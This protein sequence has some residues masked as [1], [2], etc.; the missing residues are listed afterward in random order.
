MLHL[1]KFHSKTKSYAKLLKLHHKMSDRENTSDLEESASS[2]E[3]SETAKSNG[4]IKFVRELDVTGSSIKEIPADF[5]KLQCL[6]MN[7]CKMEKLPESVSKLPALEELSVRRN[8]LQTLN[9]CTLPLKSLN[10][11]YNRITNEGIPS[12]V[13]SDKSLECVSLRG[14]SLTEMPEDLKLAENLLLLDLSYN[15]IKDLSF[16]NKGESIIAIYRQ[17]TKLVDLNLSYNEIE[18]IPIAMQRLSNLHSLDFSGNSL[19]YAE[20]KPIARMSQ[21]KCLALSDTRIDL[22]KLCS[23]LQSLSQLEDLDLS[24]NDYNNIPEAL[25][26]VLSL[27]NLNLSGNKITVVSAD[28]QSWKDLEV[29]NLS[30]NELTEL[31]SSLTKLEKL[32]KLYV[33]ENQLTFEGIPKSIGKLRALQKFQ[34]ADN[35]LSLIPEGIT[36]CSKLREIV[37]NNNC[38]K[39]LPD[40][41]HYIK[42]SCRIDTANNPELIMPPKPKNNAEKEL[43]NVDFSLA[44]QYEL[45]G[46]HVPEEIKKPK[47]KD[48][49][50]RFRRLAQRQPD[51]DSNMV[52]KGMQEIAKV[53][54]TSN[55]KEEIAAQTMKTTAKKIHE[56]IPTHD[57]SAEALNLDD[58]GEEP[59][60]LVWEINGKE[61][62]LVDES[63]LG[64]FSEGDCYVI[65]HTFINDKNQPQRK[66]YYWIGSKTDI[67][68][69]GVCALFAKQVRDLLQIKCSNTRVEM[70]EETDDF[71]ELFENGIQFMQG[72]RATTGL[73]SLKKNKQPVCMYK[74]STKVNQDINC[75][76]VP[77]TY[78]YLDPRFVYIVLD[79]KTLYVWE[80]K[81]A[82]GNNFRKANHYAK[83]LNKQERKGKAE[84]ISIKQ[85]EETSEFWQTLG[86]EP[87]SMESILHD[88]HQDKLAI[89]YKVVVGKDCLEVPQVEIP[90]SGLSKD[91]LEPDS[92]FILDCYTDMFIWTGDKCSSLEKSA[93][94]NL[95]NELYELIPRPHYAKITKCSQQQ[96][97]PMLFKCKF[98]GWE[99][100][101]DMDMVIDAL[102][103]ASAQKRSPPKK[104]EMKVDLT[105]LFRPRVARMEDKLASEIRE[106]FQH[107][108]TSMTAHVIERD[109][110]TPIPKHELG[111]FYS[112]NCYLYVKKYWPET[113]SDD[114]ETDESDVEE[115]IHVYFWQG[116]DASPLDWYIF[117]YTH[118][119]KLE[120]KNKNIEINR[121]FQQSEDLEFMANFNSFVI[122]RGSRNS[123]T[124]EEMQSKLFHI[125]SNASLL[126]TRCVEIPVDASKLNSTFCYILNVPSN[127]KV[128]VWKGNKCNIEEAL[129]AENIAQ[130]MA[131]GNKSLHDVTEGEESQDFWLDIGGKKVYEKR[132]EYMNHSR[133]FRCSN[134][135]GNFILHVS[136]KCLDFSQDELDEKDSMILDNGEEVYIWCSPSTSDLNIKLAFKT[137]KLYQEYMLQQQ[138]NHVRTLRI[139]KK[140]QEPVA[141]TRC[142]HAWG[143]F[144][145]VPQ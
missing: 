42:D 23:V 101:V 103:V 92:A 87:E 83:K 68:K 133:L 112:A 138:P 71:L 124:E 15:K 62:Q 97:P 86:G 31:P 29:L 96:E 67:G 53:K 69:K 54:R 93:A 43:Y 4:L 48:A 145:K 39:S 55:G 140:G 77:A 7:K 114:E 143:E 61:P 40:S 76:T 13:F 136:E 2:M 27:V 100:L 46:K 144:K 81:N 80:G 110:L 60:L 125:R 50:A 19:Q 113:D 126:D 117:N 84:I 1:D 38:L 47:K 32:K 90:E 105:A 49:L 36:R 131:T 66:V 65:L 108:I 106:D 6:T 59:G 95:C 98:K 44:H 25:Y 141:F 57:I 120:E 22:E 12:Y 63:F 58:L 111:H 37:L 129:H 75:S 109:Q 45:A 73:S 99:A 3:S 72:S 132:A 28:I 137:A 128:Y 74:V 88:E 115:K 91:L 8:D 21:L 35:K 85:G 33:N 119:Q 135:T 10:A 41:I 51:S 121:I 64:L 116:R 134:G 24:D 130:H 118:R 20:P 56:N 52:L 104:Q 18:T 123:S 11:N 79:E 78:E 142:F 9:E 89:L 26:A 70:N 14:N 5:Q 16:N 102:T 139:T 122:H 127:D 82:A 17:I 34:A 30:R 94:V 107:N